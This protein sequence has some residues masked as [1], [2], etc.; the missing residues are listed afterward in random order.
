MAGVKV[1]LT[2]VSNTWVPS[3]SPLSTPCGTTVRAGPDGCILLEFYRDQAGFAV[4]VDEDV[5]TE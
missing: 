1:I 5:L 4:T 2:G 3:T